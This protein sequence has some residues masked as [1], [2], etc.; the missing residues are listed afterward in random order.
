[1]KWLVLNSSGERVWIDEQPIWKLNNKGEETKIGFLK[2]GE[3]VKKVTV[4][5]NKRKDKLFSPR[6][7][8]V[9]TYPCPYCSGK[10]CQECR[11]L[12]M[13]PKPE[14]RLLT[15]KK[16]LN[17]LKR[18]IRNEIVKLI[19]DNLNVLHYKSIKKIL[20]FTKKKIKDKVQ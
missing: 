18:E 12:G 4:G 19:D 2:N 13:I 3:K 15:D 8:N 17:D 7:H 9:K 11:Y 10:S 5:G 20:T 16:N 14:W 6:E 1:M